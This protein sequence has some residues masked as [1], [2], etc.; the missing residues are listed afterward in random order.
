MNSEGNEV[1]IWY[2][3]E[4]NI[5]FILRFK[6]CHYFKIF[7]IEAGFKHHMTRML[8]FLKIM[9]SKSKN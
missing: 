5:G 3:E 8:L 1:L 7:F 9:S 6:K 2:I 4:I